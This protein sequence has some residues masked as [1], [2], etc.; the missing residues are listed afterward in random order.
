MEQYLYFLLGLIFMMIFLKMIIPFPIK[1]YLL[2]NI[3]N[4]KDI[5]YIDDEGKIYQYELS[6]L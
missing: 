2:P 5:V 4:Y 1:E 3:N 6:E